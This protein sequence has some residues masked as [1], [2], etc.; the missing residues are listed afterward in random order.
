MNS[1]GRND[2]GWKV[3]LRGTAECIPIERLVERL[4]PFEQSHLATCARC[5]AELAL[6]TRMQEEERTPDEMAAV[7]SISAEVRRR[8]GSL[9]SNVVPIQES[10]ARRRALLPVSLAAA[11]ALVVAVA[12]GVLVQDREP[13]VEVPASAV[14]TYR[15]AGIAV[16]AP[17]GEVAAA[18]AALQWKPVAGATLYEAEVLEVD[19][20]LLWHGST[21]E[22]RI[23]LPAQVVAQFVPGK[24]VLWQVRARRDQTTIADSGRQRF[25]LSN[26]H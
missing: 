20:T 11:A 12:I 13:S 3:D 7:R 22:P 9:P 25:R 17:T 23:A 1:A 21:H 19:Q 18:P 10:K 16:I 24:T 14:N 8:L 26:A 4:A 15:F 5:Q 6:W 2:D